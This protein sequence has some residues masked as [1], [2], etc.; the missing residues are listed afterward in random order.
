VSPANYVGDTNVLDIYG[1]NAAVHC[2][3]CDKV[4]VFS[5]FLNKVSGRVCPHC[6]K[7]RAIIEDDEV[8]VIALS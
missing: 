8:Q 1:N 2:T 4:F 6:G 7:S 5:G 3:S